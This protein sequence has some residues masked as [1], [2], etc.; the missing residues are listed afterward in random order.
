MNDHHFNV[1]IAIDFDLN[2]STFLNNMAF[3]LNKSIANRKNFHEDNYWI[4]NSR[5]AFAEIFPYWNDN[6]IKHL[7]SNCIKNGLII[8]GN[9]NTN[10]YDR[11]CWYTFTDK[12]YSYYPLLQEQIKKARKSTVIPIGE[13]PPMDCKHYTNGLDEIHQPIPYNNPYNNPDIKEKEK[14]KEKKQPRVNNL[15]SEFTHNEKHELLACSLHLDVNQERAAF[16]DYYQAHG[17][18]MANWNAA[19]N[20]WLRK[21]AE[22]RKKAQGKEHPVTASIREIKSIYQSEEFKQLMN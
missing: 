10:K 19:F 12:A 8:K 17:K 11:T 7:L 3:W 4:Y 16:I 14:E 21:S 1:Q 18:K 6:Q 15:N 5:L 9:F 22:F 2:I 13:N 20:N